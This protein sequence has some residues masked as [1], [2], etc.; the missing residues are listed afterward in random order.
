MEDGT[1]I[2]KDGN[3]ELKDIEGFTALKDVVFV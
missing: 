2:D 1:K 3:V